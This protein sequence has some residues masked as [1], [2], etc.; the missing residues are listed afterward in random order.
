MYNLPKGYLSYSAI[1]LWLK[2]PK[3]FR[4]RYYENAPMLN[5]PELTFGKKIATL[6]EN[7]DE[8][9]SHIKQYKKPEQEI[10]M[11][12]EGV[13]IFGYIDSFDP[14]TNSL[15]EYKTGRNPWDAVKVRKHIQLDLYSLAIQTMFGDVNDDC[16]LVWMETIKL[17]SKTCGLGTKEDAY[18]IALTGKVTSFPR[19]IKQWERDKMKDTVMSVA[20]EV[21][22]D[23]TAWQELSPTAR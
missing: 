9:M 18:G 8:S 17:P 12:V 15:I 7:K 4:R 14:E 10:N 22:G 19:T 21:S 6:L 11:T 13:K 1:D 5:T 20:T 23:Y 16:E 3:Q 2:S